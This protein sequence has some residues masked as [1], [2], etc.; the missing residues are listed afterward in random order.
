MKPNWNGT[1]TE[2]QLWRHYARF[3]EAYF[4]NVLPLPARISY[5]DAMPPRLEGAIACVLADGFPGSYTYSICLLRPFFR[6]K[7]HRF[8][9]CALL[10]EMVH[11]YVHHF[12]GQ[13]T[14]DHGPAFRNA[15][16]ALQQLGWN[17]DSFL[18]PALRAFALRDRRPQLAG[19]FPVIAGIA[20]FA[21]RVFER[22]GF[23]WR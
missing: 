18:N 21:G 15:C 11:V 6:G 8:A 3:N 12:T 20:E 23:T 7:D 5:V 4:G 16:E 19:S 2:K 14:D 9:L 1:Y 17:V 13:E 10:H 22:L